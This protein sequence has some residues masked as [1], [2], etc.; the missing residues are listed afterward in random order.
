VDVRKATSIT[1]Y[2]FICSA[3]NAP[4]LKAIHDAIDEKI[5]KCDIK[6]N[7][8]EGTADSG[9]ML[10]DLGGIIVHVQGSA[11]R[12]HYKLEELWGKDAIVYHC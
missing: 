3:D 2:V 9:W 12:R 4:Q 7:R 8:W 5:R 1:D 11:T 10:L 6:G